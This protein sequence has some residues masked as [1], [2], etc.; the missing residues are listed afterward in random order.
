MAQSLEQ[1]L[2]AHGVSYRESG[3]FEILAHCP[4]CG[5]SDPSEHLAV[6]TRRRGWRCLRSPRHR[7]KSYPRL[8]TLLLRCSDAR[9]RELLGEDA[10]APLPDQDAF[11]A[12]WRK[13]LGLEVDP[14]AS[15][16]HLSFPK[17]FRRLT[18]GAPRSGGF[19][20]YLEEPLP[21]GR[22]F[23]PAQA[24]WVAEAYDLH[25]AL[26]GQFSYR[27]IIPVHD[28][29]GQ[30]MTWTGRAINS[31][32][33]IR[34]LTLPRDAARAAPG[35]LLLG[36]PLLSKAAPARC[37][38]VCEGPFDGIAVSALGHERGVWG[39]CLFGLDLS[40]AQADLLADYSSYFDRSVLMLDPEQAWL[41]TLALR[42]MLPRRCKTLNV[43]RGFKDPGEL[44][45]NRQGQDF[46]YSLA[47]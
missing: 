25:Y 42:S 31:K 46:V 3:R 9:A 33:E 15:A 11:A 23:T 34:Y 1:I 39:T 47:A 12:G 37:L 32:A 40:E 16:R 6:S 13:Q 5:D 28:R 41:R 22:G 8:L 14:P 2:S 10:A 21:R 20:D 7:G 24:R 45:A 19:W 30:L 4:L 44:V 29:R 36:L 43:P 27:L 17:E 38:A 18:V 35:E 26:S